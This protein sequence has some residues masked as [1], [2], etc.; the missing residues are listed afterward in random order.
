MR[1]SWEVLQVLCERS[2][3]LVERSARGVELM[4]RPLMTKTEKLMARRKNLKDHI[5][6]LEKRYPES[7][8]QEAVN[9]LEIL[10]FR[11]KIRIV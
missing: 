9:L 2:I 10:L 8:R 3:A 4:I 1:E 5:G 11:L 6:L 7:E